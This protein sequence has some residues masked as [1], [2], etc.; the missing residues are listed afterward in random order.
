MLLHFRLKAPIQV[1]NKKS[2][3][4]QFYTEICNLFDDLDSRAIKRKMNDLDEFEQ[5]QREI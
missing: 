5:E 1:G 3:D 4:V 2:I